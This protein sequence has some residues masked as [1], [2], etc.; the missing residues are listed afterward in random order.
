[1]SEQATNL[2]GASGKVH[3]FENMSRDGTWIKQS[4]VAVFAFRSVFHLTVVTV[5]E[6]S[7]REGDMRPF[8]SMAKAESYGADTVLFIASDDALDRR[9]ILKDISQ[10]MNPLCPDLLAMEHIAA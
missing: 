4:G 1:M 5:V 2:H 8:A 9:Y 6:V 7:G 10:G 3:S